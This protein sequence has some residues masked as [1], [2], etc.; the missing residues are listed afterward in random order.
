MDR[1]D[2]KAAEIRTR[3]PRS[4]TRRR[5]Q[6]RVVRALL[7]DAERVRREE[8]VFDILTERAG[9]TSRL[10]RTRRVVRY[11]R[12]KNLRRLRRHEWTAVIDAV[13]KGLFPVTRGSSNGV[14]VGMTTARM[15]GNLQ[16]SKEA[17]PVQS[18]GACPLSGL[19]TAHRPC[20]Q[21]AQ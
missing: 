13:E 12:R 6:R 18:R 8:N 17:T 5:D 19:D 11:W 9:T 14:M 7:L 3:R 10:R 4:E 1:R 21:R 15:P 2:S 20:K 16:Y